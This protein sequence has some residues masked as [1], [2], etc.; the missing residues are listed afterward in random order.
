MIADNLAIALYT[1]TKGHFGYKDCYKH[2]VERMLKEIPLFD[3][4]C[5]VAHIKYSE[6]DG[7]DQLVEMETFLNK[8]GFNVLITKGDW[9]HNKGSHAQEYY[10]DML[11]VFCSTWVRSK[12]YTF[13]CED[14]ELLNFRGSFCK[15]VAAAISFLE[16]DRN[17][18]C[19]KVNRDTETDLSKATEV[20]DNLIYRQDKDYTPWGPTFTFQP[21]IVRSSEWMHSLRI[22]NKNLHLLD[23]V[24]CELM[25][26]EVFK[27]FSD[28]ALPFFFFNPNKIN[29]KHIGLKQQIEKFK[30]YESLDNPAAL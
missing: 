20:F 13:V 22:I 15:S 5:K 2:T 6:E 19:V 16:K 1:S 30:N 25:S 24:H 11:N 12:K 7:E 23:R 8:H 3:S 9:S 17:A 18:L 29:T 4:Y 27:E 28:Y 14:D 10:K 21:T 26:G